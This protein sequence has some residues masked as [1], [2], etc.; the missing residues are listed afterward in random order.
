MT[1]SNDSRLAVMTQSATQIRIASG[2]YS[3][4]VTVQ[5]EDLHLTVYRPAMMNFAAGIDHT[6]DPARHPNCM[7]SWARDI[8]ISREAREQNLLRGLIIPMTLFAT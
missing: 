8:R 4:G 7:V 3:W 6:Y 5:E 2:V 1:A